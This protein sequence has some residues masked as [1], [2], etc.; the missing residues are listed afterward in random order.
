[1]DRGKPILFD[2]CGKAHQGRPGIAVYVSDLVAD[3]AT[4]EYFARIAQLAQQPED[5]LALGVAP[6]A[7]LHRRADDRLDQVRHRA[8]RRLEH[9][10]FRPDEAQELRDGHPQSPLIFASLMSLAKCA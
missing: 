8:A 1:F 10:A 3:Q 4:D 9:D 5:L 6:P 2:R 7:A